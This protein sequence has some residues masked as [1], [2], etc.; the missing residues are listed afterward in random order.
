[1]TTSP[2]P[3]SRLDL[4]EVAS[5]L[6]YRYRPGHGPAI[7]LAH[8]LAGSSLEEYPPLFSSERLASTPLLAVDLLG[9]GHSGKPAGFD[10]ELARQAELLEKLLTTLEIAE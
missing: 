9:F 7:L 8:G 10:Y 1:M 3:F 2:C 5:T 4:P 6:A